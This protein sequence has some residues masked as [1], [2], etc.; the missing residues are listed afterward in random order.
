M[1]AAGAA[2]AHRLAVVLSHPTQYYSPWFRWLR[3]HTALEFRV[4]YLWDFGVTTQRDPQFD[5]AFQWD[6]NLLSGYDA[7]FVPNTSRNPGTHH[8]GGLRNPQ[9][10]ARLAAWQPTAILFFGYKW[11][12]H[13]HAIAWARWHGIPLLFRG[14]SHFLGRGQPG[15][16]KR[17]PLQA[18]Y[19]QFRAFLPVGAANRAYFT[20]LGVPDQKQF[21]SP[22]A[23]NTGLFTRDDPRHHAAAAA[24]RAS[25]GLVPDTRVLLFAGK[26][27]P[28]KQPRE[29]LQVF[30][31]SRPARAALVFV[32]DGAEKTELLAL[33]RTAQP[34]AVHFLPFANQTEMPGRLLLADIFALPSRGHYETWGLAVNE[35]MHMGVPALVSDRVGCQRDLVTEGETGWVFRAEESGELARGLGAAFAALDRPGERDR[36]RR[37]VLARIAGYTYVQT[38]AG[39]LAALQSI[40]LALPG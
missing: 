4:F 8:F 26:L 9:L 13:V 31:N 18:L 40:P 14:D 25:L 30:L 12:A 21:F 20:A 15:L 1:S 34:G 36:L 11:S 23:G 2:P 39:L 3:A 6:V 37:N 33:A 22:H 29:L 17:L 32:G 35:A 27:V 24:L 16:G 38:T 5:T 10:T 7:E 19:A 28:A